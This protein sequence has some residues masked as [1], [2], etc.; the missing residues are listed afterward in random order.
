MIKPPS[1]Q[2][3]RGRGKERLIG[4][5][6]WT[7][8]EVLWGDPCLCSRDISSPVQLANTKH[9]SVAVAGFR[10]NCEA[11]PNQPKSVGVGRSNQNITRSSLVSYSL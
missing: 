11:L 5:R 3:S 1:S 8:L 4:N 2:P 7:S 9:E 10:R 6:W